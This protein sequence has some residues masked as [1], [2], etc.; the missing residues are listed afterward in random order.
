MEKD[1]LEDPKLTKIFKSYFNTM[2]R[3]IMSVNLT[4]RYIKSVLVNIADVIEPKSELP[5]ESMGKHDGKQPFDMYKGFRDRIEPY[6]FARFFCESE[7]LGPLT[8]HEG[9]R[10]YNN[11]LNQVRTGQMAIKYTS[12]Q[13][14]FIDRY[15]YFLCNVKNF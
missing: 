1:V 5:G 9:F 7:L 14:F 2:A 10:G 4:S 12:T 8:F 15:K 13:A 3:E 6:W 11:M